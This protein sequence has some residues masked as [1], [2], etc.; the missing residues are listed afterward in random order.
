MLDIGKMN[1][2][3]QNVQQELK[4]NSRP[5]TGDKAGSKEGGAGGGRSEYG[6]RF[7][8]L[9]RDGPRTRAE[10]EGAEGGMSDK[11]RRKTRN[12]GY[13]MGND[14]LSWEYINNK[15]TERRLSRVQSTY[16]QASMVHVGW[17]G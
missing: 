8:V 15:R 2:C 9:A 17:K 16:N 14:Y 12:G 13:P 10:K 7:R 4:K 5:R 3:W 6:L 1:K 11:G